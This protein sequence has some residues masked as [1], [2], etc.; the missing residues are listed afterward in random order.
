MTFRA[1]ETIAV[2]GPEIGFTGAVQPGTFSRYCECARWAMF[3]EPGARE[4]IKLSAG[5]A[6]AQRL[7]LLEDVTYPS[8]LR[9]ETTLARLGRT[10]LDMLHRLVRVEDE[11]LV[12]RAVTTIVQLG[13]DGPAPLDPSLADHLTPTDDQTSPPLLAFGSAAA[14]FEAPIVIRP[15]D[16]DQFRHVNQARYVDFAD[17]LRWFAHAAELPCGFDG[18][19]GYVGVDYRREVRAGTRIRGELA[20]GT[21]GTRWIRLIESDTGVE[22]TR[23]VIRPR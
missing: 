12:A 17:D 9:I 4:K 6:R 3:R 2:R 14:E 20:R 18:P 10:S 23:I 8:T 5:V 7:E 16:Q 13:P 1:V 19:M 22:T 21:D 15:S 11:A